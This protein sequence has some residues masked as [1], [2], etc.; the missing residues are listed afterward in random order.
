MNINRA[1]LF[2][3]LDGYAA[4]LKLRYNSLKIPEEVLKQ[5]LKLL[6]DEGFKLMP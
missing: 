2:P 4:S 3:D 5:Q 1:S 6:E